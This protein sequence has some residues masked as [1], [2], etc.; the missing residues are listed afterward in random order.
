[1]ITDVDTDDS[2]LMSVNQLSSISGWNVGDN[3][4]K[5]STLLQPIRIDLPVL[6]CFRDL[7]KKVVDAVALSTSGPALAVPVCFLP[8]VETTRSPDVLHVLG[9]RHPLLHEDGALA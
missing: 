5:S 8:A 7:V 2:P 9:H 3:G 1:M 6:L 4:Q